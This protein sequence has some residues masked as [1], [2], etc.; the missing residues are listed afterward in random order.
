MRTSQAEQDPGRD[1]RRSDFPVL[2]PVP[3][4]WADHDTYGHVNNA[5]HYVVM[6]SA[7][8]GWL[9]EA[10]AVDIRLLPAL[11]VVVETSCRY[12]GEIHFPQTVDVGIGLTASGRSSV[13]YEIGLFTS[14]ETPAAI[15]RF[16]HVYVD[17][18]TRRPV[19]IPD[20][21]HRALDRLR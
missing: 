11:G 5:V 16:V 8:N 4:R 1:K 10:A 2:V 19:P 17:R 20:E 9:I 18:E 13:Q 12:Y 6:D 3:T 15:A 7:L 21:I 14:E